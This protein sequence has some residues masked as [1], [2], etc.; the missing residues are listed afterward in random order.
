MAARCSEPAPPETVRRV[1]V[2]DLRARRKALGLT[3]AQLARAARMRPIEA[4]DPSYPSAVR[5][6]ATLRRLERGATIEEARAA[7]MP[8]KTGP[9][10]G[11]RH[12]SVPWPELDPRAGLSGQCFADK[13]LKHN[14]R[15]AKP[16]G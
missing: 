11:K 8:G 6:D 13:K 7:S 15:A 14:P 10:Q 1:T 4:A 12:Q 5:L 9:K 16:L 2:L 3:V